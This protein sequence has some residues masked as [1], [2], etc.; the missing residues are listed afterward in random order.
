MKNIYS[1]LTGLL[2]LFSFHLA[3]QSRIYAPDLRAPENGETDVTPDVLLDWDAVTGGTTDITYEVQLAFTEDFSDAVTFPIQSVT[4]L[5]M[6][7]LMFGATYYWHVRAFDGG[8]PS[9]W[10]ETWSFTVLSY[11]ELDKPND[12]AM[13]FP[14]PTITFTPVTGLT[15]YQLEV[16]TTYLWSGES[17]GTDSDLNG[18]FIVDAND[19]WV[20]GDGGF[21]AHFDGTSWT[22]VDAGTSDNLNAVWFVS[23]DNG[24]I[25]GKNGTIIHYDGTTFTTVDGGTTN[26]LFDVAFADADHGWVVGKGGTIVQYNSGTWTVETAPQNQDIYTVFAVAADNVYAGTKKG[27]IFNFDG[28]DWSD[29]QLNGKKDVF[30][31]WFNDANNG[32]AA[33][34]S[35]KIFY[36]DGTDWT[37]QP[38]GITKDLYG[39]SFNGVTG[40][41]VGKN[42]YMLRFKDDAWE[43]VA[44]G[45]SAYLNDVYL[46]G[47]EGIVA[48]NDGTL[49][50]KAGEGFTSPYAKMY[51]VDKDSGN[52]QLFN[53]LFGKTFYYRIRAIHSQDTSQWSVVKSMTTYSKPELDEPSN[54]AT[55]Q[56][57]YQTFSWQEF[58]G[59]IK[60]T[61]ET[62]ETEDF[63]VALTYFS[64]SNSINIDNFGFN[65]TY[66]WRVN[67]IHAEDVSDWS[68][69]FTLT[70]TNTVVLTSPENGAENVNKSPRFD[71]EAIA[72]AGEYQIMVAQ[73][74]SFTDPKV[75]VT[76]KPFFQCQSTLGY[77][78]QYFWKVRAIAALDTSGW[79]PVW[80][81]VTEKADGIDDV[82][83]LESYT[84]YP[85]PS[86]GPF[87]LTFNTLKAGNYHVTIANAA[88]KELVSK[89][90]RANAGENKVG[91]FIAVGKGVYT[92]TISDGTNSTTRKVVIK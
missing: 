52:I 69:V 71:W 11:V 24:W 31:L 80:H 4:S 8:E 6:E 42:G 74:E 45:T 15:G 12:G 89:N 85:N 40:F 47:D 22:T 3:A 23:A 57:L 63:G 53:L 90:I 14:D 9:D 35:G 5:Q 66:Y 73:D 13:V 70:T 58:S 76:D 48:G 25:V 68:D 36:F 79:S 7:E 72:G 27:F 37:S 32:W 59:V 10:S 33:C 26:E 39:I 16:D 51:L 41:A 81:F 30:A 44:S 20:V 54:N 92:L 29:I 75:N 1:I 83:G 50:K 19:K 67:A 87:T 77:D 55:E 43:V 91:F 56:P 28:T 82:E 17:A 60:Y 21:V 86:N 65:K 49:L 84:I 64:D 34:K 46:A 18:S 62:S 61:I 88:G 78:Q 2:I 38:T